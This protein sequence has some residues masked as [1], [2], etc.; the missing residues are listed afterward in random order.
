MRTLAKMLITT[1][2]S[3]EAALVLKKYK[4][5]IIAVTGSVGKTGTKDAIFQAVSGGTEAARKSQK[6][7]NSELGIPLTILGLENAWHSPLMWLTNI[8]HGFLLIILPSTYPKILVLEVG[9]DHPGDI[10][11]VCKWVIPNI[12]VVTRLPD[13]PVHV[14]NFSTPQD[15]RNEKAELVKALKQ[16]GVFVANADDPAVVAL[17]SL[18]RAN[19]ITYGFGE[20]AQVKGTLPEIDY[21]DKDGRKVPVGM[22]FSVDWHGNSLP[23][24]VSGVLGMHSCMAVLVACAVGVARQL[25]LEQIVASLA[26][27]ETPKGRMRIIAGKNGST[28]IDDSYNS[29]P[30]ALDAALAT[31]HEVVAQHHIVLLGDMLELGKYSEEEHWKMGRIAG[32][33][34]DQVVTVGRR[35]A[36][37]AEAAK[38]AGLPHGKVRTFMDSK[39]AGEWLAPQLKTGDVVLI[40]GSQGS[41][42]NMIRMER[43]VAVLMAHPEDAEKFLVRQEKEWQS[44]YK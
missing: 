7:F 42:E 25:P 33:F 10:R 23:I 24:K 37:I 43:A 20:T 41:G 40:K 31:L 17:S 16:T 26:D 15:V 39:E 18:T 38:T 30:A 35:A 34:V 9:A 4:P 13:T 27:L 21:E 12:A 2:L 11:R 8:M 28:L 29:S 44:Q 6:S 32:R 5:Y 19:M 3:W 14:A 36:S 1:I 22:Q